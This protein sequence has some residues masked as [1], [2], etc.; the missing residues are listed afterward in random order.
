MHENATIVGGV[1]EATVA[2]T[3]EDPASGRRG[4]R[5]FDIAR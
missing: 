5:S 2:L 1:Q 4:I 3:L